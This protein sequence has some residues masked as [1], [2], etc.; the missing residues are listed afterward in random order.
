MQADNLYALDKNTML[1]KPSTKT[2]N[3]FVKLREFTN[4]KLLI[5]TNNEATNVIKSAHNLKK[6]AAKL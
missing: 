3:E 6:V 2:I 5:I 4:Q 1:E